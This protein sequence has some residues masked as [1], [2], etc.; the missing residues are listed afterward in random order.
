MPRNVIKTLIH[1]K[2]S[3][4]IIDEF[5]TVTEFRLLGISRRGHTMSD[6]DLVEINGLCG[7]GH[8][9]LELGIDLVEG[10]KRGQVTPT[11]EILDVL[12]VGFLERGTLEVLVEPAGELR[13]GLQHVL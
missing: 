3:I 1:L 2:N 5:G 9:I 7:L 11:E 6:P 13:V 10:R 8:F 4:E 12:R